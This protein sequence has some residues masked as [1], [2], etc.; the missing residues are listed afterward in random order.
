MPKPK[1]CPVCETEFTPP[2]NGNYTYCGPDCEAIGKLMRKLKIPIRKDGPIVGE[3]VDCHRPTRK[4][5]C[6]SCAA[7]W[8]RKNGLPVKSFHDDGI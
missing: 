6:P 2:R 1:I 5:R 8:K 4:Y 3:C 7:E